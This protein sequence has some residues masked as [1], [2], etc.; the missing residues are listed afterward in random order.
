MEKKLVAL[1]K[2]Q[3]WCLVADFKITADQEAQT[4]DDIVL[5]K[6]DLET[7]MAPKVKKVTDIAKKRSKYDVQIND[8]KGEKKLLQIR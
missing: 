1:Q 3:L 2:K 4:R 5:E 7:K 8:L 6:Q